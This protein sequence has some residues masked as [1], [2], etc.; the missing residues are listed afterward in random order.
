MGPQCYSPRENVER[1]EFCGEVPLAGPV[2]DGHGGH[3]VAH[4]EVVDAL[5][6][7][8]GRGDG[9]GVGVVVVGRRCEGR[10]HVLLECPEK[11]MVH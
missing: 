1:V 6:L 10:I 5:R 4:D 8:G 7:G 9:D 2:P 11:Q 3:D